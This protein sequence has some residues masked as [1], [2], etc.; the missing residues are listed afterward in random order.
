MLRKLFG[1]FRTHQFVLALIVIH[2]VLC[3]K[4]RLN[5]R[6]V[7]AKQALEEMKARGHSQTLISGSIDTIP[8]FCWKKSRIGDIITYQFAEPLAGIPRLSITRDFW[9]GSGRVI[10]ALDRAL[11]GMC[12]GEI[13]EFIQ[14]AF[15][16]FN[17]TKARTARHVYFR[18]LAI[19]PATE[20]AIVNLF[21]PKREKPILERLIYDE[22]SLAEE[23]LN[24]PSASDLVWVEEAQQSKA[25]RLEM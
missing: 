13:R 25:L 14:P 12:V 8:S 11:I 20:E 6:Y 15:F 5:S 2:V 9:L 23:L 19:R 7:Q 17:E 10:N 21:F 18:L 22:K 24:D 16:G 3:K 4:P 1:S